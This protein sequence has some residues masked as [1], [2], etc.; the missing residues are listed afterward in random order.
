MSLIPVDPKNE[1]S[2]VTLLERAATWLAEAVHRG[3][4]GEVA[5][6]KAQI[7][8]AAEATK[9]LNLSKEIQLDA[10]EMV[11]RAEYALGKAIRRGQADG[12]IGSKGDPDN[13][14]RRDYE[15]A[16]QP[17]RV[18][19]VPDRTKLSPEA[20]IPHAQER[21]DI[22]GLSDGVNP[23]EFDQAIADAKEQGNLSR[24]NVVRKV[25][26][27]TAPQ[28]RDAKA[29]VI[30]DLAS[31]G[32]SSRQMSPKV[33]VT[34]ARVR[35]IAR[36]YG[37]EIPADKIVGR[38]RRIDHTAA[39]ESAVTELDNWA[40]SL[41]FIDFAE[42]DVAEADEWVASLTNSLTELRRFI[43]QIKETTHV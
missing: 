30:E 28:T 10:Q 16:G 29:D 5:A 24:A 3:E 32:Y 39:V 14:P 23:E 42:V 18:G 33:G 2:V 4:A 8:T 37:I 9:Q 17:V 12:L 26:Q 34:D 38:S 15:R 35:E 7:A 20:Y 19:L 22:Y 21:S 31:Q 36:A 6:V 27:Q 40:S 1:A 13:R 25:K 11:R 43:K 41:T